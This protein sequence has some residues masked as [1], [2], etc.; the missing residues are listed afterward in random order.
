MIE[1]KQRNNNLNLSNKQY[2]KGDDG[3]Y[4]TPN[5]NEATGVLSWTPSQENMPIPEAAVIKGGGGS[6]DYVLTDEDKAEI[7]QEVINALPNGD[8]VYY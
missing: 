6:G 7:V 8:E 5:Y 2:L 1:L 3:G 4:Y